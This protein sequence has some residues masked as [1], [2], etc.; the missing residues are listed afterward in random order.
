LHVDEKGNLMLV[1]HCET[2]RVLIKNL[3]LQNMVYIEPI[4]TTQGN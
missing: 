1:G 3:P 4:A 2:T